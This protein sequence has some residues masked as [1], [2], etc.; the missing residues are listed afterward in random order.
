MKDKINDGGTAFPTYWYDRDS[1][2]E[3]VVREQS[4]GMTLRDYFAAKSLTI[5]GLAHNLTL[6]KDIPND[7]LILAERCYA[8][9]D[10][11]LLE[12]EK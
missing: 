5:I 12:R 2:G 8:I 1:T 10:A 6:G 3:M 9:A 4:E 11:M 7:N